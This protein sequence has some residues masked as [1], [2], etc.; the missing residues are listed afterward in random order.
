MT[1]DSLRNNVFKTL[2]FPESVVID[3]R[4]QRNRGSLENVK[5]NT[6]WET[7]KAKVTNFLQRFIKKNNVFVENLKKTIISFSDSRGLKSKFNNEFITLKIL[8]KALMFLGKA[9]NISAMS[10]FSFYIRAT[11][12]QAVRI[13]S[14]S[15]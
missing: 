15:E 7:L 2:F 10:L 1:Y 12:K 3:P 8:R 5:K 4:L 11:A 14:S 6:F 13:H 9:L